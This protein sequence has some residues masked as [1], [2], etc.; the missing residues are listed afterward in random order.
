MKL[1]FWRNLTWLIS[2]RSGGIA[3]HI[4]PNV[5]YQDLLSRKNI[6]QTLCK[7]TFISLMQFLDGF[8][9]VSIA[10]DARYLWLPNKG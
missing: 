5:E 2:S 7:Q 8:A 1:R 3:Q 6:E 9:Q 10:I 4:P